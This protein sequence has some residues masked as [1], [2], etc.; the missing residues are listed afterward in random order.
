MKL[1]NLLLAI[2]VALTFSNCAATGEDKMKPKPYN[3][4][5]ELSSRPVGQGYR[6]NHFATPMGL[7]MSQ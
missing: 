5:D 2:G 1:C 3:P 4:G 7:P 6:A